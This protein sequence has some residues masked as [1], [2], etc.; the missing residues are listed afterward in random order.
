MKTLIMMV[1]L[2]R[3]GKST[4]ARELSVEHGAPIVCPDDI[5]LALHGQPYVA[6]AENF[7]W[8]MA[9]LMVRALFMSHNTVILDACNH[10]RD[11]RDTWQNTSM[12]KREFVTVDT[13]AEECILRTP[14]LRPVI[15]RMAAAYQPVGQ[16]EDML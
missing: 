13:P 6:T 4:K 12:W 8:A 2:P 11:R 14:S 7:V 1:G 16:T 3:S 5:R 10:T 15:E 9:D